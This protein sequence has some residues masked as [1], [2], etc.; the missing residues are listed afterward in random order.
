[1]NQA[2]GFDRSYATSSVDV[3]KQRIADNLL[4]MREETGATSFTMPVALLFVLDEDNGGD[5]T[6]RE[7]VARFGLLN[8]E[9]R[10]V[11]DFHFLGWKQENSGLSFDLGSF[12]D[13]RDALRRA[14]VRAFGGNADLY[15][16]DAWFRDGAVGLDFTDALYLDLSTAASRKLFPTLGGFFQ[17]LIAA[18]DAVRAEYGKASAVFRISDALQL[19]AGRQSLI[20]YFLDLWAKPIGG[21]KVRDL[22]TKGVGPR[23]ELSLI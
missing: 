7:T 20:D 19:A 23:I 15:L 10:N 6:A 8:A 11:L 13:C 16:V 22:V 4:R 17:S 18:T 3:L 9:S 1:M 14:G 21:S 2:A 12:I 5:P